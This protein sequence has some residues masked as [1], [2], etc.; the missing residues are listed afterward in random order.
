MIFL[1]SARS[2][3]VLAEVRDEL[4]Q[5]AHDHGVDLWR[6]DDPNTPKE[7]WV[8]LGFPASAAACLK[9]VDECDLYLAVFHGAYGGSRDSHAA[10]IALTDLEFFQAVSAGK[11]IRFYIIEPHEPEE[12]LK[13]LLTLVR[14]VAPETFGGS[15]SAG[16]VLR[17][18]EDDIARHLD[19][20]EL[21]TT[22]RTRAFRSYKS[23]IVRLRSSELDSVE[24]LQVLPRGVCAAPTHRSADELESAISVLA[25]IEDR[26]EKESQLSALLPELAAVPYND[27]S[28][29][30]FYSA[31]DHFCEGWLR[32][33]AW[34]G[35]HNA[36]RLGRLAMLNTQMVVRCLLASGGD[37]HQIAAQPLPPEAKIGDPTPWLRAFSLGGALASEYYSLAKEQTIR[38]SKEKFLRRG[39]EF[40]HVAT[41]VRHFMRE[42]ERHGFFAGLAAIRGH[43]YLELRDQTLD[44]VAAFEESLRLRKDAGM[45]GAALAEGKA[46]LGHALV[47][48]G[49]WKRGHNLLL[50]GVEELEAAM[51]EG[52][53]A[54]AKLK[55]AE[56]YL[57]RW[58]IRDAVRQVQEAD[59]ICNLHQ[60][61]R[62]EA[63]GTLPHL[64]LQFL[65]LVGS[66]F[67]KLVAERTESGYQY[68]VE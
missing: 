57:R 42:D 14:T 50:E 2:N 32:A 30:P 43:I 60:I 48:H 31:W 39:L 63:S 67:P 16:H 56:Y 36:L 58:R 47:Q 37:R 17:L 24:G 41:R 35:H 55:M 8:R 68:R 59:A 23:G 33:T 25:A 40:L 4:G 27:R 22:W 65:R 10:S 26:S 64:A 3:E 20:P 6:F 66:R 53:A 44:P 46:D 54:R 29:S 28:C 38:S 15:G 19:C 21:R 12:E 62:R 1:S 51:S 45:R 5:W 52:F 9:K 13:A 7:Y 18:I 34:R 49:L 61:R 11:K